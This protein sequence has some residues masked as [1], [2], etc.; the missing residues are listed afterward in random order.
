MAPSP[1]STALNPGFIVADAEDAAALIF[2]WRVCRS[3]VSVAA[4]GLAPR[5][6]RLLSCVLAALMSPQMAELPAAALLLDPRFEFNPSSSWSLSAT[7]GLN[8][9]WNWT[10]QPQH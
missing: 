1:C 8:E 3:A 6:L 9:N 10:S 2:V 4:E 7:R 5:L